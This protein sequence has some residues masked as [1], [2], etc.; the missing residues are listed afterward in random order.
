ME[1]N[2]E[3]LQRVDAEKKELDTKIRALE[4]A[5]LPSFGRDQ[6]SLLTAQLG[7]MK[8]YSQILENRINAHKRAF[9]RTQNTQ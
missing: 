7:V 5:D 1:A 9:A 3:W 8:A 2:P 4:A 6:S